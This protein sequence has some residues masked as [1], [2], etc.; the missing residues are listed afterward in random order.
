MLCL[1]QLFQQQVEQTPEAI[2][3]VDG[4]RRLTYRELDQVTDALAGYLLAHGVQPD[5][6]VGVLMEKSA[7][8]IMVCMAALKAGGAYLPLDMANPAVL[9]N[10]LVLETKS[11]VIVTKAA[12]RERLDA[13]LPSTVMSMDMETNWRLAAYD[14]DTVAGIGLDHLAYVVYSSGTTGEPKGVLAPHRGAVY[15]YGERY[16]ISSYE[17]G[18]RVAC[19]VFFVWEF[20][21]PLLKGATIYVIPDDII[22]D[23]KP[24]VA[25]LAEHRI[26]EVLFTPSLMET[27]LNAID[28]DVLRTALASLRVLWLNGEVVTTRLK[29]RAIDTLPETVRLINTYSTSECHDIASLDLRHCVERSSSFCNVGYPIDGITLRLLD[30][31]M[32]PVPAGEAG[33][34]YIG[35]P[36]V[37]RG[38]LNKPE[39]TA[40]RFVQHEGE[41]FY[42]TGDLAFIHPDGD[43][44]IRGRCDFMVKMR[45]Y[46]IHLGAVET[47]LLEHSDV[48]SC[49]VIAQ[50]AEGED[51]RLVAYVV[52]D[53]QADWHIHA[54]TG[55][56]VPLREWLKSQLPDYMIP[57]VYIALDAIPMNPTTGKLNHKL[58]PPPPPPQQQQHD[59]DVDDIQL[60]D[61]DTDAE[62]RAAMKSLWERVLSLQA[63]SIKDDSDFFD[64]GGHSLLAVKLTGFI[65]KRF[66][67]ELSVKDIYECSTVQ[68]LLDYLDDRVDTALPPVSLQEEARLSPDIIPTPHTKPLSLHEANAIFLT[69]ATGFLGAFLLD[70]LLRA[71]H[72][73][74]KIH[75]LAR[76]RSDDERDGLARIIDNLK[77]YD[78]WQESHAGRI[79]W[80]EGDLAQ[81]NLVLDTCD[82]DRLAT[83]IDFIFHCAAFVNYVYPYTILKPHTVDA[84]Q[85]VLRLASMPVRKPVYYTASFLRESQA[86]T[87][88]IKTSMPSRI[89]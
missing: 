66:G 30:D 7:D 79:V 1:P 81:K 86:H 36:C 23:P 44:E 28:R 58:L 61:T 29:Q 73:R 33:E 82:F 62:R 57:S 8:Y 70:E 74:V 6:T 4:H 40:E 5:T 13:A 78:L 39:L 71:T 9:L 51:K 84:T 75:C 50:G 85:E 83:D 63:G 60:A 54:A 18:D 77:H 35:G 41:R 69:G 17:P 76:V 34:L 14:R 25:F 49:A 11:P 20:F 42:R 31:H 48:K 2:A 52:R 68:A 47:A 67:A 80:V 10:K 64:F 26:H 3:V 27:V 19:N 89:I 87:V 59:G 24:L 37:V 65:E 88:K 32:Q 45:G 72:D 46:S 38:Y 43:I 16:K 12:Y 15:S 53:E 22:Y 55:A 56:C 21:R